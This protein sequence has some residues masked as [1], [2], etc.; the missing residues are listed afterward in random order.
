MFKKIFDA[1][2]KDLWNL[3]QATGELNHAGEKGLLRELFLRRVFETIL[4]PHFGVGSGIIVDKWNRQSA[5]T[6]LLIYDKRLIPPLLEEHG[7]G[8]YPFDAVLRVL[9]VKSILNKDGL[10]QFKSAAWRLHPDNPDGLKTAIRGNLPEGKSYYPIVGV[11][12]YKSVLQNLPKMIEEIGGISGSGTILCVAN[13]GVYVDAGKHEIRS[14]EITLNTRRFSTL[15]LH[16]IEDAA[17]SR[18]VFRLIE[19]LLS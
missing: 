12:A 13:T 19:W 7:H 18:E 10:E 11:Y 17:A 1:R 15:F 14:N 8:I 16:Y 9:E 5:Q 6:D 2:I 3:Y 4:P